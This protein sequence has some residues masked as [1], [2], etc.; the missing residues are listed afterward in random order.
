MALEWKPVAADRAVVKALSR[1]I[2]AKTPLNEHLF[3]AHEMTVLNQKLRAS[4][5]RAFGPCPTLQEMD[6]W[7]KGVPVMGKRMM[8]YKA[9]VKWASFSF[10]KWWLI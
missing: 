4:V 6:N 2:V 10:S 8:A 3:A 7:I 1:E 5:Y 9:Q